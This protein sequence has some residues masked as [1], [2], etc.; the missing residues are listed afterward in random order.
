MAQ[1]SKGLI[2]AATVA[3]VVVGASS[4]KTR[5]RSRGGGGSIS[6]QEPMSGGQEELRYLAEWAFLDEEWMAFLEATAAGESGFNNLVG[7]GN[8][9]LF[10]DWA[11]PNTKA[12]SNLQAN[13]AKAAEVAYGRNDYL[14]NC[15]WPRSRYT[16]GS[17]GWFGLLPANAVAAFKGTRYECIDPWSVFDPVSSLVEIV[18]YCRRIMRWDN[19]KAKPT[20][21][22]LRVGIG[23][24]SNMNKS[25]IMAEKTVSFGDRVQELGYPASFIHRQVTP[26]PPD[27][28]A[29][30]LDALMEVY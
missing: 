16:F 3:L 27:K 18:D 19:F 1:S 5:R 11:S 6:I 29:D 26:L 24:P 15:S 13:E 30:L 23:N 2:A 28:P 22:N 4:I 7:L 25:D 8:P 14:K 21:L 10:P 17:G 20:W 9:A 12:S